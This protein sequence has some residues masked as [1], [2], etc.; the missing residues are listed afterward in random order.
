[1]QQ[2][3]TEAYDRRGCIYCSKRQS[4]DDRTAHY[5][6]KHN[7]RCTIRRVMVV[8]H[9]WVSGYYSLN[10]IHFRCHGCNQDIPWTSKV[11]KKG[12]SFA[13]VEGKWEFFPFLASHATKLFSIPATSAERLFSKASEITANKHNRMKS[14]NVDCYYFWTKLTSKPI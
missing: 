11:S 10:I 3:Y 12:R 9:W 13:M 5:W 6:I 14:K 2:H 4:T 8:F 1:M 7:S